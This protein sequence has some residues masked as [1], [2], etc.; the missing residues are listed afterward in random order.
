M[1]A[2]NC[3]CHRR[4]RLRGGPGAPSSASRSAANTEGLAKRLSSWR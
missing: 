1:R 3:R 4:C 2:R